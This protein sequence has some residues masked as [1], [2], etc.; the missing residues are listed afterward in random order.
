MPTV[1]RRRFTKQFKEEAVRLLD[2]DS[3]SGEEIARDLGVERAMLYRWKRELQ[4][5]AK[6][7]QNV[8][9]ALAP[10]EKEELRRL[11]K[12]VT[13][14]RMEKEILKKAMAFFAKESK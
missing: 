4:G 8:N 13:Q 7:V 6:P 1:K 10:D 2:T 5:A 11:R 12:E 9:D 14:L 3:R